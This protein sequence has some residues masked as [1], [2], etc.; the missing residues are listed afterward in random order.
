MKRKFTLMELIIVIAIIAILLS[1][2]LPSMSKAK[3]KAETALCISQKAQAYRFLTMYIRQNDNKTTTNSGN[4]NNPSDIPKKF[5]DY[6]SSEGA[7]TEL[8]HCIYTTPKTKIV[9]NTTQTRGNWFVSWGSG[10]D[11]VASNAQ[12]HP[13]MEFWES[14]ESILGDMV[15]TDGT[16]EKVYHK[17][18]SKHIESTFALGDGHAKAKKANQLSVFFTNT[19]GNHWK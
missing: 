2:L 7:K 12:I 15:R 8:L 16:K 9:G 11:F 5:Y 3:Y 18:Q 1:L 10:G 17:F 19:W 4:I 6:I 13:R 14:D